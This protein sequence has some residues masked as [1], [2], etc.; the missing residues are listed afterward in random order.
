[1]KTPK[2]IKVF[3]HGERLKD[4]YPYATRFQVF[5]YKVAR[6]FR[7][8]VILSMILGAVA[9]SYKVGNMTTK[10]VTVFADKEVIVEVEA[11][12]PVLER[13]AKCESGGTHYRKGQVI[14]NGAN[15]NGS[16]DV[17]KYQINVSAWGAKATELGLDLTKEKDNEEMAKWI[18][19]NK[20]TE[21]WYASRHC[22]NK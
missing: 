4:V 21:P 22:W 6:F 7:R 3:Y 14:F 2:A 18:Y 5:K 10:E 8:L 1:M 15:S 19:K 17:G 12:S 9:G 11:S 20:G 13:I 16:V